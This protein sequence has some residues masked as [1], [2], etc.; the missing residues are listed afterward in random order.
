MCVWFSCCFSWFLWF[1]Y[2]WSVFCWLP[3]Y[4]HVFYIWFFIVKNLADNLLINYVFGLFF[5]RDKHIF[6]CQLI[7][8]FGALFHYFHT[9]LFSLVFLL[10]GCF[11]IFDLYGFCSSISQIWVLYL[12]LKCIS[13][14]LLFGIIVIFYVLNSWFFIKCDLYFL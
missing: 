8:S 1:L 14:V 7:S 4:S 10:N 3:S 5:V 11:V 13:Y 6:P 9:S 12:M 2:S